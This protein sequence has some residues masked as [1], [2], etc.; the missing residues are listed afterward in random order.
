[1]EPV[2]T[3]HSLFDEVQITLN[4]VVVTADTVEPNPE[5]SE[6]E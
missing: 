3:E 6:E 5:I 2:T 4:N 1:M